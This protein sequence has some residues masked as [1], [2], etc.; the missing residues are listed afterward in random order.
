MPFMNAKRGRQLNLGAAKVLPPSRFLTE[1]PDASLAETQ[2]LSAALSALPTAT[3]LR[4]R[5]CA[6]SFAL[7]SSS[8]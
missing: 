3:R 8:W 6:S 4:C 1:T 5:C 7:A 2:L